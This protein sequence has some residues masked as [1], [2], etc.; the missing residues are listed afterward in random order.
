MLKSLAAWVLGACASAAVAQDVVASAPPPLVLVLAPIAE[1]GPGAKREISGIVRGLREHEGSAVFWTQN[2][3]GDEPRIYPVRADGSLIRSVREADVPGTLIAGA[4]NSDWED[5]AL[6]RRADGTSQ[7]VVADFGNNSNARADLAL[8]FIEEPEPTESRTSFTSKVMF[9][10]PDQARRPAPRDDFNFDAEAL[11]T[12]GEEVYILSKNRSDEFTKLYR[13]DDR[14]AGVVNT[15]TYVDRFDDHLGTMGQVTGADCSADGLTLAVLTY[16]HVWVFERRS[17][18]ESFF[19]GRVRR[20][21]Y[22][23]EGTKAG[24][25]SDSEAICFEKEDGE[26][27]T[28]LIA[29]ESRA[30]LYRV[31]LKDVPQVRGARMLLSPS[32]ADAA[33]D[34]RVVSFNIRYGTA[35]DGAN[36]WDLRRERVGA[37]MLG[38]DADIIGMQEVVAAQADWVRELLPTHT[39]HGVGRTDGARQ[40]EFAP[41]LFRTQRFELEAAG[42][43]WLSPTPEVVGSKGWDAALERMASWVRLVDRTTQARVLVINTHFDHRG[44]EARAQSLAL[45]RVRANELAKGAAVI[46]TGDFNTSADAAPAPVLFGGA[47][48]GIALYDTFRRVYPTRDMDE[49]TF[50]GWNTPPAKAL[51]IAGA[52][53]DW[54]VASEAFETISAEIDRRTPGGRLISDHYPVRARL[55]FVGRGE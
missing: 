20:V 16:T 43:F 3:S 4:I 27:S 6:L 1:L 24:E 32:D 25:E 51:T 2:D 17:H 35:D 37:A 31:R 21:A 10:Y 11:F 13:L 22:Q 28:L 18:H 48:G 33:K 54:I 53:I 19:S 47:D 9:R 29:D 42:H 5:I 7:V 8:Y 26:D 12:V 41:I 15:A 50:S 36:S 30:L 38:W 46:I 23:L 45:V 44:A 40:G 52:R 39:F 55:R 49:A 14:T 34:V